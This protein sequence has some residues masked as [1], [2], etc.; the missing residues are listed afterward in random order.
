MTEVGAADLSRLLQSKRN[1]CSSIVT[2]RKR[3]LRELFVVA[4]Q[5]EGLPHPVLT[6]PDAPTTTPAE[7]QFLQ[8]NDINQSK[9]L[10]EA[11]IPTR[12]TFSLEV[13]KKS[14]AKSIFIANESVPKQT[15]ENS[16]KSH[17]TDAQ[18]DQQSNKAPLSTKPDAAAT[19]T[20]PNTPETSTE[21]ATTANLV[22]P[23]A[24]NTQAVLPPADAIEKPIPTTSPDVPASTG[25]N[26]NP[27]TNGEDR[28]D[29][30]EVAS[31]PRQP[32]VTFETGTKGDHVETGT[33]SVKS[34]QGVGDSAVTTSV[35]STV[36]PSADATRS[37]DA[38][39]SP[40]STAQSATTPAVHDDAS[41]DTSP[42]HEGPQYVE[43]A[44]QENIE[45]GTRERGTDKYHQSHQGDDIRAPSTKD[46]EDRVLEAPPDSAE[47][48]LLQESIRS[49]VAAEKEAA[50]NS[51]S[52]SQEADTAIP[53][54]V[55]EDVNMSD[56]DDRVVKAAPTVG[57][58]VE[59]KHAQQILD[60]DAKSA[61]ATGAPAEISGSKEIPDSQEEAPEQMDVDA[62]EPKASTESQIGAPISP[63]KLDAADSGPSSPT[64]AHITEVAAPPSLFVKIHRPKLSALSLEFRLGQCVQS[65]SVK[66]LA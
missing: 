25:A 23:P 33:S 52:T 34:G 38:L 51:A 20:R 59:E 11:S 29:P 53:A 45:D 30:N 13:L 8:A 66:L 21:S 15:P 17:V 48:Q 64:P 50:L 61:L 31:A 57:G 43:P 12:P 36:K 18:D 9:T 37:A 28:V 55:S 22:P 49:N 5:S 10:N 2:S 1:E 40:G 32:Q 42:E 47:A 56:V 27:I 26:A 60:T 46:L 14:L 62:P 44:E 65:L 41:T 39:S 24:K 54:P 19:S 7:W 3:K 58:K 4:T 35:P 6:N 16:N 63:E